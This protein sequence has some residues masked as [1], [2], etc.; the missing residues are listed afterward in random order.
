ML[1]EHLNG[2]S[3]CL[4]AMCALLSLSYL[5]GMLYEVEQLQQGL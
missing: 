1:E 2:Q 5:F 3:E 4:S